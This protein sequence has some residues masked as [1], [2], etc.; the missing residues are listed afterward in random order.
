MVP[1]L[2]GWGALLYFVVWLRYHF[3]GRQ[4]TLL[5]NLRALWLLVLAA[6]FY[7]GA[8]LLAPAH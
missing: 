4:L 8:R 2:L 5:P 1:A 7:V 6:A 3:T